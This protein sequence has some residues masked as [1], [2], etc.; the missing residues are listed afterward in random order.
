[1][2]PIGYERRT[3][4]ASEGLAVIAAAAWL[5]RILGSGLTLHA[6]ASERPDVEALRGRG[7]V[8]SIDAPLAGPDA[9]VRWA[10]RHYR[11]GGAITS[12]LD[13]RYLSGGR[14]RPEREIRVSV[15]AR[16][17]GVPTPA[18]ITGAWYRS[19]VFYRA[20]L[21]TE[22]VPG[23]LSLADSLFSDERSANTVSRLARSGRLVR[24]LG[25]K[26]VLHADLNAMNI[27]LSSERPE[28]VAYVIDLD[29]ASVRDA[30]EAALGDSMQRR[31]ERSLR[32]LGDS[33]GRPLSKD[34]W[35]ALRAGFEGEA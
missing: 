18:V 23:A 22:L 20:D 28:P 11:R 14:T 34:D 35:A 31:L 9:R 15:E 16:A 24:D 33:T 25:E 32:E 8:Y 13:D 4:G 12:Y 19:G 7:T 3:A 21:V 1:V 29:R 10:V 26:G 2:T 27:L 5:E 6:W 30:P 17:R